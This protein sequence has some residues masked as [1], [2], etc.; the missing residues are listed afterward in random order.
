MKTKTIGRR[1]GGGKRRCVRIHRRKKYGGSG[2]GLRK[3]SQE[4]DKKIF[5]ELLKLAKGCKTL[6]RRRYYRDKLNAWNEAQRK[7]VKEILHL[8]TKRQ[9]VAE[10]KAGEKRPQERKRKTWREK[11]SRWWVKRKAGN[12][13]R[14][15]R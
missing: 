13:G 11:A 3:S 8:E 9:E 15:E 1:F 12:Q 14:M 5:A 6:E 2:S 4:M 7:Q 10:A